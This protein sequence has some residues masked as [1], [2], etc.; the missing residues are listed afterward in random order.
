MDDIRI[1]AQIP[2]NYKWDMTALFQSNEAWEAEWGAV[3]A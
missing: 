1:R 2:D 3:K